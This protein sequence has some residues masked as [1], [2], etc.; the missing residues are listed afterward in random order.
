MH[1]ICQCYNF[2]MFCHI[3]S[4]HAESCCH[5][6]MLCH[7]FNVGSL[8]ASSQD[9]QEQVQELKCVE[10]GVRREGSGGR[11]QEG[12]VRWEGSGGRGERW[13]NLHIGTVQEITT[14]CPLVKEE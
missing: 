1:A 13:Y 8:R 10:G 7:V 12:G 5:H 3:I 2:L 6:V 9:T 14:P 4:W 11:G